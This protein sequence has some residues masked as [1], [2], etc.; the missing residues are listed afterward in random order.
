MEKNESEYQQS[1]VYRRL[2]PMGTV[3]LIFMLFILFFAIIDLILFSGICF[4]NKDTG[5]GIACLL[6][7]AVIAVLSV[8]GTKKHFHQRKERYAEL[9]QADP[10]FYLRLDK[11]VSLTQKRYGCMYVLKEYIYIPSYQ[12]LIP[13]ESYRGISMKKIL[14]RYK[15]ILLG[16][17]MIVKFL[18]EG[19]KAYIIHIGMFHQKDFEREY[20]DFQEE[21]R[22]QALTIK[23][24][25]RS[26][27]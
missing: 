4:K 8:L 16:Y 6:G 23:K 24:Y 11:E 1:K 18:M 13:F 22:T 21:L 25:L 2:C 19:D 5:L 12:F 15:F 20:S 26:Y 17:D 3:L 7:G 27:L 10:N 14:M 9:H